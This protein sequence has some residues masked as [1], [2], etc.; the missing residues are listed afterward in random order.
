MV[1]QG[2]GPVDGGTVAA[3]GPQGQ[4]QRPL[5]IAVAGDGNRP[6]DKVLIPGAC[7]DRRPVNADGDPIQGEAVRGR[8]RVRSVREDLGHFPVAA[9]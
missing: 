1:D 2:I 6:V 4:P 3:P 8:L 9:P 7:S 5:G